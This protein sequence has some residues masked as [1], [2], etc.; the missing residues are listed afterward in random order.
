M[1]KSHIALSKCRNIVEQSV[2]RGGIYSARGAADGVKH[3]FW[4][5]AGGWNSSIPKETTFFCAM[6]H[7]VLMTGVTENK[8]GD[9]KM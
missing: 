9:N 1:T 6:L 8:T 4:P 3:W 5:S 2:F 7:V